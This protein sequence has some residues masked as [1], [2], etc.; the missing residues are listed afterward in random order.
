MRYTILPSLALLHVALLAQST[1]QPVLP[2]TAKRPI[3]HEDVHRWRKIERF[4][5]TPD[6]QWVVYSLAPVTEGD[7]ILCLWNAT[8]G[9]T[10]TFDR[11]SEA[12][13]SAD[14][15]YLVFKV[16]PPLDTLKALRRRRVKEEN[17]PRDSL[18]VYALKTGTLWKTPEVR[19]FALPEKWSGWLAY[20]AEPARESRISRD[21]VDSAEPKPKKEDAKD[22]GSRLI[23]RHLDSGK[24]D[25]LPYVLEYC[26]SRKAPGLLASCSGKDTAL[27]CG[28]YRFD[29]QHRVWMPLFQIE[30]GKFAR[31]AFDDSGRRAAFLADLDT[32]KALVRPRALYYWM[33]GTSEAR[34]IA[35]TSSAFLFVA[36][37]RWH[38]SEHTPLEFSEDGTMLYFG[39]APPFPQPDTT[40]L[41][42]EIV[43]V[44]VWA[45]TQPRIYSEMARRLEADRKRGFPVV[46]HL[47]SP[48][49]MWP[50]PVRGFISLGVDL[51]EWQFQPKR[52]ALRA[53]GMTEEPYAYRSQWEGDVPRDV[54]SVELQSGERQM[55]IHGQR[56]LPYLSP[57]AHYVL[58]WHFTDTAWYCWSAETA[59]IARLTDNQKV[60]FFHERLD[61][62]DYP[63]PYGVATWLTNDQAVLLY[64]RYDIWLFDPSGREA[65]KRLTKG[66]ENRTVHRYIHLDIE[67]HAVLADAR[68][69]V[70]TLRESTRE[71]GYAWLDL[72][73]GNL[74][75]WLSGHFR[76]T[77]SP[78]KAKHA[79]VLVFTKESYQFFP[80]LFWTPIPQVPE[81]Y[82]PAEKQ[83]STANPHQKEYAWGSIELFSWI[84]PTGDTLEGLLVKPDSFNAKKQ[85][86]L[87]VNLYERLS[88]GLH[89]HRAPEYHRS[90]INY[91][92]YASRGYVVFAPDILYRVGYPGQ[93][94]Y[95]A[96]VSGV[97]ALI[98]QGFI[99]AR[100]IGL[101]GHSWGG[102]QVAYILTRTTLFSCAVAGAPVANMTSAY[103]GIRWES[104]RVRQF[105]YERQQSRIGGTLWEYPM[106]YWE[107]SPLFFLDRVCTP[108]LIMH[109]DKDGA[110]PWS[111]GIELYTGLRR[112]GKP[113]W[114][115]NY[116]DEPHWPTKLQN[117]ADFQLRMQQFFD[118][119]LLGAPKPRWMERGVPPAEK[120]VLQGLEKSNF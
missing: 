26:F 63:A 86:P 94:A 13:F 36:S 8:S 73:T 69:L 3:Q 38:L 114:M 105:Q 107:N 29:F 16:K 18:A 82:R 23:I 80:D 54:Y 66:R 51:S 32:S 106:R 44:E 77:R 21:S 47:E 93:S 75:P 117:R 59:H 78:L 112:L 1:P 65:P 98:A 2:Q 111:Q 84:S 9:K 53:L 33:E 92:M 56:C 60:A 45:H 109:N 103:G 81:R 7:A 97:T 62:P 68:L 87:I 39:I 67:E 6:G 99:D 61:V 76:Y 34:C 27:K 40:L 100:R 64:D 113:V 24:E 50:P 17:L 102:Y 10:I 4:K 19:N 48:A 25:T 85:Y 108:L 90:Q 30:K 52:N 42:E 22:N 11:G 35:D 31:L 20:Q 116:N 89:Q 88:D 104:G 83:I 12:Q 15:H 118:H 71:E 28:V 5:V 49:A 43:Q 55:L 72:K 115:L 70:H 14:G 101:Q 57:E 74:T 37:E 79:D 58:W 95:D 46:C 110:V 96:V 119:Y 41:P 91:T 120:G